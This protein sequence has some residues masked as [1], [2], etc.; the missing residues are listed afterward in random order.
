MVD[1]RYISRDIDRAKR[2][3]YGCESVSGKHVFPSNAIV[4]LDDCIL[5]SV[6][7]NELSSIETLPFITVI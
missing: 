5:K 6:V 1:K 4:V 7:S 3:S 2:C